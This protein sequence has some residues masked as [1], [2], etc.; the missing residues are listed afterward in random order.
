MRR[1]QIPAGAVIAIALVIGFVVWLVLR[2]G[3]GESVAPV[4]NRSTAVP[5]SEKGLKTL[6]R[7]VGQPIYWVGPRPGTTYELTKTAS[8]RVFI[9]YL[10]AGVEIGADKPYLTIG[11]YP[12]EDAFAV[13]RKA[14]RQ[15]GSVR[16]P[17]TGGG[18]AFYG[19]DSPT[20]VYLAYRGSDYQIEVYDPEDSNAKQIVSAGQVVTVP[21]GKTGGATA[22]RAVTSSQLEDIASTL[23]H[24]VYWAGEQSGVKYEV[25]ETAGDRVFVRYLPTGVRVGARQPYLT[26]G[27]YP[28]K[29]AFA[30]A[31]TL[32]RKSGNEAISIDNGVAFYSI[33]APT[34][35]YLAYRGS[36]YQVE[37]YDPRPGRARSLVASDRITPVG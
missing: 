8:D 6:A 24:P 33:A 21:A 10:P 30:V 36:D 20:H 37:V 2:G 16:I 31:E 12:V 28:V 32:A 9:R 35:V 29:G 22:A 19:K 13:T 14:S 18:V 17:I 5:I 27:T 15:P 1:P 26:I 4:P 11:T 3:G 34:H 7:A 25:T 23:K